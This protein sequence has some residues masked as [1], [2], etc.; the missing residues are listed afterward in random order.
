M[1]LYNYPTVPNLKQIGW[2]QWKLPWLD[3]NYFAIV[4]LHGRWSV[5]VQI[6]HVSWVCVRLGSKTINRFSICSCYPRDWDSASFSQRLTEYNRNVYISVY[7]YRL[8]LNSGIHLAR[9]F[10]ALMFSINNFQLFLIPIVILYKFQMNYFLWL[11]RCFA[12]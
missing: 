10:P 11:K 9:L 12:L 6:F 3:F 5:L 8:D 4:H 1:E 7:F 2:Q